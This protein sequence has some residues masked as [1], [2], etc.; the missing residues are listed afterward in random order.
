[1]ELI[2]DD[3]YESSDE[4]EEDLS[5]PELEPTKKSKASLLFLMGW[6]VGVA[7]IYQIY[8]SSG[9]T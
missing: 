6:G 5:S 4:S 2:L 3:S 8:R 1:M 9:F 7:F